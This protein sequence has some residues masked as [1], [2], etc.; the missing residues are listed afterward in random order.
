MRAY[1]ELAVEPRDPLAWES[2][3]SAAV[4]ALNSGELLVHPTS[5]VYGI[6]AAATAELDA[7]I[8]RLKGRA[9]D[10]PI[11]RLAGSVETLRRELPPGSW[12]ERAERLAT[13]FWPG[14]LTLILDDGSAAGVAVR[15]D[16]HPLLLVILGRWRSLMSS[17]S[18]N[19]KGGRP[20]TRCRTVRDVLAAMPAPTRPLTFLAAVS[21][22]PSTSSTMVSLRGE[23]PE[24]LRDGPIDRR[25]IVRCLGAVG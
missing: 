23:A 12:N 25:R 8:N 2:G 9:S 20:A 15:V 21:L 1:R 17:T 6:G 24:I 16:G 11:I 5:T 22:P 10:R 19:R 3:V 13:E 4:K 18:L 14:P 7:E